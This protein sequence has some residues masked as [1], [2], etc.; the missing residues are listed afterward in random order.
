MLCMSLPLLNKALAIFLVFL[1]VSGQ[2][3]AFAAPKKKVAKFPTRLMALQLPTAEVLMRSFRFSNKESQALLLKIRKQA[4]VRLAVVGFNANI[5]TDKAV[6]EGLP[7]L[8]IYPSTV[9]GIN[10][11]SKGYCLEAAVVQYGR[12]VEGGPLVATYYQ[13]IGSSPIV[14][15]NLDFEQYSLMLVDVY[16]QIHMSA[17]EFKNKKNAVKG[18]K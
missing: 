8:S 17:K 10:M 9:K 7:I 18:G 4:A 15:F 3:S 5:S 13:R 16:V 12:K 1:F 11:L 2:N 6:E 14:C